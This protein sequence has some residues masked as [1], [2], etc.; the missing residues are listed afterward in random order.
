MVDARLNFFRAAERGDVDAKSWLV[1]WFRESTP[2]VSDPWYW[3]LKGLFGHQ[4]FLR[5]FPKQ[6]HNF[7]SGSG[8]FA[9]AL[10]IGHALKG[11][12]DVSR[13][14]IFNSRL[15]NAEYVPLAV[16]MENLYDAQIAA[17]RKAVDTWTL[18]GIRWKVVKDIRILI[19]KLI[20]E[21][22]ETCSFI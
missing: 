22:R 15:T 20:W 18:T 9:V 5:E 13:K 12:I 19:A 1:E 10:A 2:A 16:Q 14:M 6:V 11:H 4:D 3:K 21:S 17:C 8:S 7:N